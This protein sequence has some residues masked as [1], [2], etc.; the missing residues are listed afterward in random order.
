MQLIQYSAVFLI[1]NQIIN[2][3]TGIN[4]FLNYPQIQLT[5]LQR[6]PRS[7]LNTIK[8]QILAQQKLKYETRSRRAGHIHGLKIHATSREIFGERNIYQIFLHD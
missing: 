4:T 5:Y 6:I 7:K 3:T 1:I 8:H 2:H